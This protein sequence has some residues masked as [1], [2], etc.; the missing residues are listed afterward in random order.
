[1]SRSRRDRRIAPRRVSYEGVRT[2]RDSDTVI[3]FVLERSARRTI[4]VTVF[5]GGVVRVRAP[6]RASEDSVM[7]MVAERRRW[8]VR[9]QRELLGIPQAE[10]KRFTPGSAVPFLGRPRM[11]VVGA[12]T[13]KRAVRLRRDTILVD[14]ATDAKGVHR[15]VYHWYRDAA[16]RVFRQRLRVLRRNPHIALLGSPRSISLRLMRRRWGSCF[17]DRRISLNPELFAA[18]VEQ[19]DYV[20]IHELCH[21]REHNHS[22]RFYRLLEDRLPDWR[23]RRQQLNRTVPAGF[24]RAPQ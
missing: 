14:G 10:E 4:G 1:M 19:I 20:I 2:Y 11:V 9:K 22:P 5:P 15:I 21:F 12:P 24:L 8:I 23:S 3:D 6:Q 18:A 13:G 7:E 16:F 17:S